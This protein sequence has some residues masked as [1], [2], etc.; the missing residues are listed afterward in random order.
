[1]LGGGG[2]AYLARFHSREPETCACFQ[3]L[4]RLLRLL[5][6][7]TCVLATLYSAQ[8][9]F[10]HRLSPSMAALTRKKRVRTTTATMSLGS[11]VFCC[12]RN[13]GRR[14]QGTSVLLFFLSM[15]VVRSRA[16]PCFVCPPRCALGCVSGRAASAAKTN[17]NDGVAHY[18]AMDVRSCRHAR[19]GKIQ[20][21]KWPSRADAPERRLFSCANSLPLPVA[22]FFCAS[23]TSCSPPLGSA[24]PCFPAG[25]AFLVA[26]PLLLPHLPAP[27]W[28]CAFSV[29]P[30][31]SSRR[32]DV[33]TRFGRY[34]TH[35]E[36]PLLLSDG[37]NSMTN[38]STHLHIHNHSSPTS[39]ALR[40]CLATGLVEHCLTRFSPL[41]FHCTRHGLGPRSRV[42]PPQCCKKQKNSWCDAH[43][44]RIADTMHRE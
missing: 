7:D 2:G 26:P 19:V 16:C 41:N 3:M 36:A 32:C 20:K 8:L 18:S 1:M 31:V 14:G 25:H 6:L 35:T 33:C 44:C 10:F 5:L 40:L 12:R 17:A 9:S 13:E 37:D 21:K 38:G 30:V 39:V 23:S 43:F 34:R 22:P 11:L 24:C 42:I 15:R 27:S 4:P 29:R 28:S